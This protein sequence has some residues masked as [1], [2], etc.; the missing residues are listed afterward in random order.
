MARIEL[1]ITIAAAT[2]AYNERRLAAIER[3]SNRR[4]L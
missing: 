3:E 2:E 4:F 1:A